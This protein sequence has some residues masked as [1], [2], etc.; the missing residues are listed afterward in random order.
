M[1]DNRQ[2]ASDRN[3]DLL[4]ADLLDQPGALGLSA[5]YCK[6]RFKTIPPPSNR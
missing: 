1:E 4:A 5:Y 6:T 3:R 2:L